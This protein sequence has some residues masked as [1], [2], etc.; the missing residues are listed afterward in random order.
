MDGKISQHDPAH[1]KHHRVAS[2][3]RSLGR[4]ALGE[5]TSSLQ[6]NTS[7]ANDAGMPSSELHASEDE[8]HSGHKLHLHR[9]GHQHHSSHIISQVAGWLQHEKAKKAVRDSKR[10]PSQSKAAIIP[11]TQHFEDDR[12]H[13]L[14]PYS[15]ER[16]RTSSDASTESIDLDRLER[17]L[18]GTGLSGEANPTPKEDRKGPHLS[19]HSFTKHKL[20]RR[21]S[22]AAS[23]DTD[24]QDG[25]AVVPSAE[26]VLDNTKTLGYRGGMA[27]SQNNLGDSN[28][29]ALKEKE[30][31]LHFKNEIVRLA[32]T[33]RLKGWRRVPLDRGGDIDVERLSGAMTNAVYV[34]SPPKQLPQAQS[35]GHLGTVSSRSERAPPPQ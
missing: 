18:A 26:V 8:R 13:E 30:A 16:Q 21:S 22:T 12:S 25:D 15:R 28:K 31:W 23:S 10:Q 6:F 33:L 17:I 35:D 20:L 27:E 32:H 24:Y 5:S 29:R 7:T 2:I 11:E 1:A 34:V 14:P 9:H 3:K 4:P 19:R